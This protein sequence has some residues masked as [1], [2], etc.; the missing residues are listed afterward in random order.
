MVSVLAENLNGD[1]MGT[2]TT[3]PVPPPRGEVSERSAEVVDELR[4]CVDE[5]TS[6][7]AAEKTG[8]TST[9]PPLSMFTAAAAAEAADELDVPLPVSPPSSSTSLLSESDE[10]PV[11]GMERIWPARCGSERK[12]V[13]TRDGCDAIHE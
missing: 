6:A 4:L 5:A 9:L 10:S 7:A 1:K 3:A 2:G 13:K 11:N 12:R 8:T